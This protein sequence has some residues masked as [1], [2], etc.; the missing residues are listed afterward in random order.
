MK[1]IVLKFIAILLVKM[2]FAAGID[3]SPSA[4]YIS[5]DTFRAHCDFAY[6][7]L[8]NAID[9][10]KIKE[11]N[12]IFISTDNVGKFFKKYHSQIKVRYIVVTHNS[13]YPI[14]Q[15]YARY[16]DDDKIIAWFGI[17]VENYTHP[18][19]HPIPIGIGNKHSTLGAYLPHGNTKLIDKKIKDLGRWKKSI[20]LYMNFQ[21]GT[22]FNE[23]SVVAQRFMNEPYCFYSKPKGSGGC[24][25]ESAQSKFLDE[26][27]QSKFVLSPRGNG[28]DCHRTWEAL[29]MGAYPIV[30]TS[31]LDS[32]YD[33]LPV[34]IIN[35]WNEVTQDFLE[36]KYAQMQSMQFQME[37]AY[38]GYWL[39]LIDS[40]KP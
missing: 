15:N 36:K 31:T 3:R 23:R 28:L 11:G 17:N 7:E 29:L 18:K 8:S 24:F 1:Y 20:L 14:N 19:L 33:D 34:V 38:I 39:A 9:P 10:A 40:Y 37:K 5:G 21:V 13:D 26:L 30:K 6:D 2:S 32:L 16:L 35:D 25:V 12:V 4:P 27:A 22:N